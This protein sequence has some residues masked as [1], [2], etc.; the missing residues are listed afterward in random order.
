MLLAERATLATA[1]ETRVLAQKLTSSTFSYYQQLKDAAHQAV[2]EHQRR[3]TTTVLS[4]LAFA[5]MMVVLTVFVILY[6]RRMILRRLQQLHWSV[7]AHMSGNIVPIPHSGSDEISAL[8]KAFDNFANARYA[9]EAALSEAQRETEEVNRQL[10]QA[11]ERLRLLS[12]VDELTGIANRRSLD[13][14]LAQEWR[15]A[16]RHLTPLSLIMID[17]DWF[18]E[19]NDRYGH[20]AGDDC[21]R[22]VAA[23]FDACLQRE[24]ERVA[25][26]GGEEFCVILPQTTGEGAVAC[27]ARLQRAIADLA[28]PHPRGRVTLS[29]GVATCAPPDMCTESELLAM[30]D[31]ALYEAKNTGRNRYVVGAIGA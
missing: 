30:A 14:H 27:A 21:L 15:R 13:Q 2:E 4:A 1:R 29:L 22:Q 26:Y 12:E 17:I 18:K 6:I 7:N 3:V 8:G 11:N 20:P 24:G 16:R 31:Q 23:A 19:Y 10:Q 28:L 25:R 9:A 5:L